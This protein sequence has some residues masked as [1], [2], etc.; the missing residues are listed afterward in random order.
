VRFRPGI[1]SILLLLMTV[2]PLATS[3]GADFLAD[4]I[5][6]LTK[7]R[8]LEQR[9]LVIDEAQLD[10]FKSPVKVLSIGVPVPVA[11]QRAIKRREAAVGERRA[12]INLLTE[13]IARLTGLKAAVRAEDAARE[14]KARY[15]AIHSVGCLECDLASC[16]ERLRDFLPLIEGVAR[17]NAQA[18]LQLVNSPVLPSDGELQDTGDLA[19]RNLGLESSLFDCKRMEGSLAHDASIQPGKMAACLLASVARHEGSI[20]R[21]GF[22]TFRLGYWTNWYTGMVAQFATTFQRTGQEEKLK[23]HVLGRDD[24]TVKPWELFEKSYELHGG[25]MYLAL[26]AALIT[27]KENRLEPTFQRRLMDIRG[28]RLEHGD[29]SG[30]WYHLFGT[31]LAGFL[32]GPMARAGYET[33][34]MALERG[35]SLVQGRTDPKEYEMDRTGFRTMKEF[36]RLV[37]ERYGRYTKFTRPSGPPRGPKPDYEAVCRVSEIFR[38]RATPPVTGATEDAG[39]ASPAR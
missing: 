22:K 35:V 6:L 7:Q 5:G 1:A 19:V 36:D 4:Y 38:N 18:I 15:L 21:P 26:L 28:N 14:A 13:E 30:D 32:Y 9:R 23:E 17:F 20:P 11:H 27:V 12:R 34:Y 3:Q 10:T 25:D 8:E 31:M 24:Y 37:T 39:S 16:R 29:N 2:L 33:A